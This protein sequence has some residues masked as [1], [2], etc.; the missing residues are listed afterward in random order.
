VSDNLAPPN[1]TLADRV[2]SLAGQIRQEKAIQAKAT[3]RILGAAAAIAQNQDTMIDEV[4]DMVHEDLDAQER[5][6]ASEVYTAE[7]LQQQFEN[8]EAAKHHF[9][10]KARGWAALADKLNQFG[11][12]TTSP[13]STVQGD[14]LQRLEVMEARLNTLQ[15]EVAQV[16]QLLT[17]LVQ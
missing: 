2:R 15:Q 8:F 5:L 11:L 16:L 9:N 12:P 1:L 7:T 13:P 14:I 4:V 10:L 6:S 3:A 17:Q